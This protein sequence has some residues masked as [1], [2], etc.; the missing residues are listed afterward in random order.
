[1]TSMTTTSKVALG[2]LLAACA[3]GCATQSPATN[4][5]AVTLTLENDL[6]TGSDNAYSN[7]FGVTWVSAALDT[8]DD[9]GFVRGWGRF[10]SFLPG[11][12]EDGSNTYA[13]WSLVQ[14]IHTPDDITD[15]NPPKSDQ[16]YAG[17][18]YV[19]SL[20]YARSHDW[21][22]SWELK[23]GV[24]GP[25]SLAEHTQK[26]VHER[27]GSDEPQGWHTQLPNEPVINAGYT[28]AHLW[29]EG[30]VGDEAEWRLV[31]IGTVGLGNYF[32]GVG[33]GVYGEIGWNLVDVLGSSSL[34]AGLNAASTIGVGPVDGWSVAFFGGLGGYGV[35]YY[36][37][38]DGTVFSD[39][40]SVDT[41]PF[42]GTG[43]LGCAV[44][45]GRL[46]LSIAATYSTDAFE[47]QKKAAE[48]GTVSLSW[49]F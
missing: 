15:P 18:L 13:A 1:M 4:D 16:P 10:W 8:Y 39:S 7:G 34:R 11:I 49:Y 47:G 43:S 2:A 38:L 24:V 30:K 26:W 42:V 5:G 29:C 31:P 17:V 35:G 44:R 40:R 6:F 14:E 23:L 37:P 36:L 21:G 32:T 45:H 12:P 27:I 41:K 48:F 20:L 9:D 25:A 33:L 46:A 28:V 3:V 22:Q 19:D